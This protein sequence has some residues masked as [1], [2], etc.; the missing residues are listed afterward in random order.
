MDEPVKVDVYK[1]DGSKTGKQETLS[2]AVFGIEPNDHAIWMA[3]TAEMTNRRQGTSSSKN[4]S[5]A[6]GGGRK[7]WRQ[8][9]RG[10]ARAGTIRSPIW[11][12]GGRAF[13]PSPRDYHKRLTKKMKQLARRSALSYKARDE[14]IRLVEDFTLEAPKSKQMADIMRQLQLN[15]NK[16]LMLVP[17][18]D[19]ILWL[20]S[21]NLSKLRI[22]E[23]DG[24]STSDV[25]NADVLLIQRGALKKIND[26][27]GK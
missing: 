21:R 23:A 19:R 15:S 20:S 6:R 12:G 1:I 10:T 27:L 18:V 2:K 26:V 24:F 17:G 13:G 25:L 8:K 4:R 7:P 16:T 5:A 14:K 9:G 3:V 11:V 22:R